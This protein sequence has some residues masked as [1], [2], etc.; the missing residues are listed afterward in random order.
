MASPG[1]SIN[2]A[3]ALITIQVDG[4][5]E[6]VVGYA[7]GVTVQEVI[8]LNRIDVLG[9]IESKDI[10]AIGRSVSGSIGLMRMVPIT[11]PNGFNGGGAANASLLPKHAAESDPLDDADATGRTRTVMSYMDKGFNLKIKDAADYTVDGDTADPGTG[12]DRYVIVGCRPS[13][14]SFS[15][16]RGTL[17]GVNVTFE[18]I[19]MTEVDAV[20]NDN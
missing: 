14:H 15:L 3:N 7:T 16:S 4:G 1:R 19:A 8:A 2:G 17:M 5:D 11:D 13:S 12:A 20:I 18:A 10:E 9:R 6:R